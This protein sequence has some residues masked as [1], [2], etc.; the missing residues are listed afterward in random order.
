MTYSSYCDN[1]RILPKDVDLH[2]AFFPVQPIVFSSVLL[3]Q[4]KI[5]VSIL[6]DT[7]G[8]E[9]QGHISC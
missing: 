3:L 9:Q 8:K 6:V 4:E 2:Q 7:F 5:S 1:L